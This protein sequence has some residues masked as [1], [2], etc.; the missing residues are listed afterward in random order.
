MFDNYLEEIATIILESN[1]ER[2][3]AYK[4]KE[5]IN[6]NIN[7]KII[8]LC[9]KNNV[10]RDNIIRQQISS[11]S[12]KST[13]KWKEFFE[14]VLELNLNDNNDDEEEYIDLWNEWKECKLIRNLIIHN[15][16]YV[17][18]V[19]TKKS[20][21]KQFQNG[22]KVQ[23]SEEY[24]FQV[25]VMLKNFAGKIANRSKRIDSFYG[26]IEIAKDY[27][28]AGINMKKDFEHRIKEF[29]ISNKFECI[30]VNVTQDIVELSVYIK[31]NHEISDK[32]IA[33][34]R[35]LLESSCKKNGIIRKRVIILSVFV[36]D[37]VKKYNYTLG[38]SWKREE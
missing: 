34:I 33:R 4:N 26:N 21:Y 30:D 23:I 35:K 27:I 37:K 13:D 22:E 15:G 17:N 1:C 32:D 24:I 8:E 19:Y 6:P 7:D 16:G 14:N 5:L 11:L 38:G 31:C 10:L 18:E 28:N 2:L 36:D 25:I 9:K 3:L 20:A 12:Y 29:N